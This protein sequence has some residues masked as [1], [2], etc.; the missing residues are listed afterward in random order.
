[1]DQ[2]EILLNTSKFDTNQ[3]DTDQLAYLVKSL[4]LF[5]NDTEVPAINYQV[6]FRKNCTFKIKLVKIKI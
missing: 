5:T 6:I 4:E 1:M 2:S 3:L